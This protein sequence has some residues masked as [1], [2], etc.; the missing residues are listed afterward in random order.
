MQMNTHARAQGLIHKHWLSPAAMVCIAMHTKKDQD[1]R[2]RGREE[3]RKMD[4]TGTRW[5]GG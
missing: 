4:E 3:K 1:G 5:N 2:G